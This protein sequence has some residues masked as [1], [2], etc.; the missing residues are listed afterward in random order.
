MWHVK[1]LPDMK[2]GGRILANQL[3]KRMNKTTWTGETLMRTGTVMRFFKVTHVLFHV[4][5]S[6][7]IQTRMGSQGHQISS[8]TPSFQ[9]I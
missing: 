7:R 5:A 9:I 4:I 1:L 8:K 6:I 2:P 3:F